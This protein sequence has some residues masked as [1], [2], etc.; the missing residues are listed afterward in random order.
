MKEQEME[1][2][3]LERKS[4]FEKKLEEQALKL[5]QSEE[6]KKKEMEEPEFLRIHAKICEKKDTSLRK[7]EISE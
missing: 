1:K 3:K 5:I 7:Q 6:V 4:S 2:K